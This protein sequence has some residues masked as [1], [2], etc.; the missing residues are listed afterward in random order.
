MDSFSFSL[1]GCCILAF[2]LYFT[3]GKYVFEIGNWEYERVA[4]ITK[5]AKDKKM[6]EVTKI[7]NQAMYDKK[8]NKY[9]YENILNSYSREK[10]L[11]E[12][13]K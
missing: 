7:I 10:V 2:F 1:I 6:T 3:A 12:M 4:E 11:L 13:K 8:I 9:E 5:V